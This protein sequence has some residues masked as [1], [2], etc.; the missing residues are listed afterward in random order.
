M[1]EQ[2]PTE[3]P[4]FETRE[5]WL[6]AAAAEL[7]PMIEQAAGLPMPEFHV[8]IGFGGSG[9]LE[10]HVRGVCWHTS[11]SADTRNQVFISPEIGDPAEAILVLLHEMI[12]VLWDNADGHR[13]RFRETASK[14]GLVKPFTTATPDQPLAAEMM[15]IAAHLGPWP[16][17]KL[18]RTPVPAKAPVGPNG[19]PIPGDERPTSGQPKQQNRWVRVAC[20]NH[21]GTIRLSR[22]AIKRGAPLCGIEVEDEE[23]GAAGPCATRMVTVAGQ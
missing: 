12:H 7:G 19:E 1:S 11:C 3:T 8:S 13:G 2:T 18:S 17:A 9:G 22:T 5:A 14:L 23:T 21:G 20:P 16:H 6:I 4:K 10:K 15:V